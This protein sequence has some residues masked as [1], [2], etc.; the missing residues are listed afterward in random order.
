MGLWA[1]SGSQASCLVCGV[2]PAVLPTPG[3]AA[4]KEQMGP[5]RDASGCECFLKAP[6]TGCPRPI[7][8]ISSLF[9]TRWT[10]GL[11]QTLQVISPE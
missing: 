7:T 6:R 8:E 10:H 3:A 2:P 11:L 5:R 4:L 9:L 1:L